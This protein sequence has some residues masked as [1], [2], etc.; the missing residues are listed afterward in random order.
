MF[1]KFISNNE[2]LI[3]VMFCLTSSF[4]GVTVGA[5]IGLDKPYVEVV[6]ALVSGLMW[7]GF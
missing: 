2:W 6:D 5:S 3:V 7:L 4:M 1:K